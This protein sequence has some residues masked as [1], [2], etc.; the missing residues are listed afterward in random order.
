MNETG[1]PDNPS[2][3][4]VIFVLSDRDIKRS[5]SEPNAMR[6]LRADGACILKYPFQNEGNLSTTLQYIIDVGLDSPG[7]ILIQSPYKKHAYVD[8][9]EAQERFAQ[10]KHRYFMQL[11]QMLGAK[12]VTVTHI[13]VSTKSANSR[14]TVGLDGK[15]KPVGVEIKGEKE[16]AE[17]LKAS[18]TL[19]SKFDGGSAD[20]ENA[21][22]FLCA[23]GLIADGNMENLLEMRKYNSNNLKTHEYSVNLSKE[24]SNSLKIA[25]K[26]K[27]PEYINFSA[28][29]RQVLKETS[30]FTLIY[31]VDF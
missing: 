11:C 15:L 5:E 18:M 23:T 3:R 9:T 7:S 20:I 30:E 2:K 17:R 31:K 28:D 10:D 8:A 14:F 29:Y 25:G 19:G 27:I 4:K 24:S 13:A 22:K 6:D 21:E 1:F 12:E 16:K 26:L